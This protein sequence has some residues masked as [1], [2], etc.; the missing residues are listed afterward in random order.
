MTTAS[1]A[2]SSSMLTATTT[3]TAVSGDGEQAMASSTSGRTDEQ[4]S[5]S[6]RYVA[7]KYT[8]FGKVKFLILFFLSAGAWKSIQNVESD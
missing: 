8:I 2:S 4:S 3:S 7:L 5:Q 1:N 6:T